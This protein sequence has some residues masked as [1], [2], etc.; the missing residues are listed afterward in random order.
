[1]V[2]KDGNSVILGPAEAFGGPS[3]SAEE[4]DLLGL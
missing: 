4:L 3:G 1:M 2:Q